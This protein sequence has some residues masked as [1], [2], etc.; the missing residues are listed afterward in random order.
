MVV[1]KVQ[2][3]E[4]EDV[5]YPLLNHFAYVD[6]SAPQEVLIDLEDVADSDTDSQP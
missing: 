1:N 4:V 6:E 2:E 3:W 5:Y